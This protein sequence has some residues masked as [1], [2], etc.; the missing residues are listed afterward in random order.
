MR[1]LAQIKS[2]ES[3]VKSQKSKVRSGAR[4]WGNFKQIKETSNCCISSKIIVATKFVP[5]YE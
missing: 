1:L 3:K 4:G 5:N 2:Q